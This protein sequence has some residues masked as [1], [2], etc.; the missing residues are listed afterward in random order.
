MYAAAIAFSGAT[1]A[2]T[3]GLPHFQLGAL[4]IGIPI[5]AFGVIVAAGVLIGASLLR[6]YAEWHGVS[7]DHIRGLLGWI[8]ITGFLG[9]HWFDV[10]AYEPHKLSEPIYWGSP[11]KWPVL[12]R[13]WDGISSYGGFLGGA[14]GFAFYV[15]WKRLPV[16]LMADIAIVG[17]LPAFSIGRIGCTVVSDH[18]G[19]VVDKANWYAALAMDYPRGVMVE[20]K[21]TPYRCSFDETD[22]T[23]VQKAHCD[24]PPIGAEDTTITMWNLG[25]IELLYLIPVNIII[26]KLAFRSSKRM[27]A[28]YLTVLT[29]VLYAP[30]RFFMDYLRPESTDPRHLG[31]TFA[32]WASVLAFG[33]SVYAASRILKGGKPADIVAP[34]SKEAQERLRLVLKEDEEKEKE[35]KAE[36]AKTAKKTEEPTKKAPPKSEPED[37]DDDEDEKPA[38]KKPAAAKDAKPAAAKDAVKGK[39]ADEAKAEKAAEKQSEDKQPEDKQP[40]AKAEQADEKQPEPKAED[41]KPEPK[42]EDKKPE[43][44]AEDKKPEAKAEDKPAEAKPEKA[45]AKAEDKP[46]EK[47]EAKAEDKQAGDDKAEKK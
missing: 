45:E 22:Y 3:L 18:I 34:T 46:V 29:G 10:L 9:A 4:D 25:L 28:G 14:M 13:I 16:R 30:V 42:A 39:A 8:T 36:K 6:R 5:Q 37:D 1:T 33:V 21:F 7:D 23:P 20:G 40:A 26:L 35:S 12:L 2:V 47:T 31:L 24:N 15:W 43:P 32:Q 11:S 44:K 27:P 19:A 38:A 41:K 17:L